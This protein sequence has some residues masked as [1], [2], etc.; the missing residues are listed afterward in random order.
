MSCGVGCRNGSDPTLLWLWYR[1]AATAQIQS[2]AWEPPYASS[3]AL[4]RQNKT[5]KF[6]SYLIVQECVIYFSYILPLF[7]LKAETY[8]T[9]E[10]KRRGLSVTHDSSKTY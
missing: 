5:K 4:K 7:K 10:Y 6:L 1:P 2:L 3:V 9:E 8:I